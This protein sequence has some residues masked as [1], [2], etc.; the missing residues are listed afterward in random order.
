MGLKVLAPAKI[1]LGLEIGRNNTNGY[2]NVDMI[3]QSISLHDEVDLCFSSD[4]GINL[5]VDKEIN[6]SPEKNIAYRAA[7]EFFEYTKIKNNGIK[8]QIKKSIPM[9]AGLAG[10]SADGAG[11]I[12]GLNRM[13]ETNLKISEMCKIGAKVGSDVPFCI[14]GGAAVAKGTGTELTPINPIG[15]CSILI[16]KPNISI[17]TADAYSRFDDMKIEK[18]HSMSLL[19][20]A[21]EFHDL[22]GTCN[23]LYNRFEDI[24]NNSEIF[25]IKNN[26]KKFGALGSLMTGSGSAVYGIFDDNNKAKICLDTLQDKYE[27][28]CISKP[29]NHGALS[30]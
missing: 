3:M 25:E 11:V 15:D 18:G 14:V 2:H 29:L 5:N 9:C 23:N 8:I 26:L 1:N 10:G 12:V 21:L 30:I 24:I 7:Q 16:I 27:F 13:F 4:R 20:T 28:A 19:K 22:K 17:S 6:C